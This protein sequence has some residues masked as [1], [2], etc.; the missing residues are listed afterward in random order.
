MAALLVVT[1]V[2][3]AVAAIMSVVAWRLAREEQRRSEARVQTLAAEIA[4][5]DD[6]EPSPVEING[7]FGAATPGRTPGSVFGTLAVGV[8][9]V[10]TFVGLVVALTGGLRSSSAATAA[11]ASSGPALATTASLE[12]TA[13]SHERQRDRLIVRGVVLD[14]RGDY[15]GTTLSAVVSVFDRTGGLVATQRAPIEVAARGAA[16]GVESSFA[17]TTTGLDDV[18]RYRVSFRSD[19]RTIAHIDRRNPVVTAQMP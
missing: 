10:G 5:I 19:D 6:Q 11:L 8:L 4:E 17:V 9:V 13:L 3:L 14:P 12:L 7:L 18:Y 2:S 16:P 1:I 15:A